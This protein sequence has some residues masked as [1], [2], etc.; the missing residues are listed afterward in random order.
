MYVCCEILDKPLPKGYDFSPVDANIST[1][2]IPPKF[3]LQGG[4]APVGRFISPQE[5]F[6]CQNNRR[7][8]YLW[9]WIEYNDVFPNTTRHITKYCWAIHITGDPFGYMPNTPGAP[10][11]TGALHFSSSHHFEGNCIDEE[12]SN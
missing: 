3:E 1:G 10:P 5:I 9:G 4:I 6:D 8:I 11:T 2:T 7:F 12:C